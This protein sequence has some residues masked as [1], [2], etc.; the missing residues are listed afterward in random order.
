MPP[1]SKPKQKRIQRV[2][3]TMRKI[4]KCHL[5][6]KVCYPLSGRCVSP[7][8][9]R[10]RS[11]VLLPEQ[12]PGWMLVEFLKEQ[13]VSGYSGKSKAE[14]VKM[15]RRIGPDSPSVKSASKK[16]AS[17]KKKRKTPTSP[18]KRSSPKPKKSR[19]KKV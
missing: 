5:A 12:L 7:T 10:G 9:K 16:K 19:S 2:S 3:C 4:S 13:G 17:P 18:K 11:T 14:L 1:K 6:N 15:Y 8:G